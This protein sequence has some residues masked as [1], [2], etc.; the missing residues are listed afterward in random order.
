MSEIQENTVKKGQACDNCRIKKIKCNNNQ[1]C[2]CC[3]KAQEKIMKKNMK[4]K[5]QLP[6]LKCTYDYQIHKQKHV[7]AQSKTRITEKQIL[8]LLNNKVDDMQS[9]FL[10]DRAMLNKLREIENLNIGG[11]EKKLIAN[12]EYSQMVKML[13]Q[14][15]NNLDNLVEADLN[16]E[17]QIIENSIADNYSKIIE[18]DTNTKNILNSLKNE[19]A[20]SFRVLNSEKRISKKSPN[21]NLIK[22]LGIHKEKNVESKL[23]T[24]VSTNLNHI[25]PQNKGFHEVFQEREKISFHNAYQ[26]QEKEGFDPAISNP[27]KTAEKLSIKSK[28]FDLANPE[29]LSNLL[30]STSAYSNVAYFLSRIKQLSDLLKTDSELYLKKLMH[31]INQPVYLEV[32]NDLFDLLINTYIEKLQY[33]NFYITKQLLKRLASRFKQDQ[34]SMHETDLFLINVILLMSCKGYKFSIDQTSDNTNQWSKH[35]IQ[36]WE[37]TFLLNCLAFYQKYLIYSKPIFDPSLDVSIFF[38]KTL[39]KLQAIFLLGHYFNNSPCPRFSVHLFSIVITV[40]Q[41][42]NYDNLATYGSSLSMDLKVQARNLWICSFITEKHVSVTFGNPEF[43]L[44]FD[45]SVLHDDI[46]KHSLMSYGIKLNLE[47]SDLVVDYSSANTPWMKFLKSQKTGLLVIGFFLRLQLLQIETVYYKTIVASKNEN[48]NIKDTLNKAEALLKVYNDFEIIAKKYLDIDP[49]LS[50]EDWI[51][52]LSKKFQNKSLNHDEKVVV[53]L[54]TY[55]L[56]TLYTLKLSCSIVVGDMKYSVQYN[57]IKCKSRKELTASITNISITQINILE[58][59][60]ETGWAHCASTEIA[61]AYISCVS[62]LFY[63]SVLDKDYFKLHI[64]KMMSIIKKFSNIAA[65]PH[66]FD[67]VKWNT[68]AAHTI[69]FMRMLAACHPD[70]FENVL[71]TDPKTVFYKEYEKAYE[72]IKNF[73]KMAFKNIKKTKNFITDLKDS[74]RVLFAESS[75]NNSTIITPSSLLQ[76]PPY[77]KT[78]LNNDVFQQT[79]QPFFSPFKDSNGFL[80][81]TPTDSTLHYFNNTSNKDD[82]TNI[83]NSL[84]FKESIENGTN[85]EENSEESSLLNMLDPKYVFNF[86]SDIEFPYDDKHIFGNEF[87]Y[88]NEEQMFAV[89]NDLDSVIKNNFYTSSV[90]NTDDVLK[91]DLLFDQLDQH[92]I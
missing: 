68:A 52:R 74:E 38:E 80:S 4:S 73:K 13:N 14:L 8:T 86:N 71:Q 89:S 19:S 81:F 21:S 85:C 79:E 17:R 69:F 12:E 67:P 55:L 50:V 16:C 15:N 36:E 2:D 7:V 61:I 1:P 60:L 24:I 48:A 76:N 82:S 41:D 9:V 54:C 43:L 20:F 83:Q 78:D 30:R 29:T 32:P 46:F 53:D 34:K 5:V 92:D 91:D 44:G 66:F 3:L 90:F 70:V 40:G 64:K 58:Y 56:L 42:F 33:W 45:H 72:C 10:K 37:T 49:D 84:M 57:D 35:S 47:T 25:K 65:K 22:K 27:S 59:L 88:P 23:E 11:I 77:G 75:N 18:Y 51:K 6:L 26:E 87:K 39:R 63:N 28:I 62:C 31:N